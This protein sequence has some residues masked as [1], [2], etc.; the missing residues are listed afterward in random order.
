MTVLET[1]SPDEFEKIVWCRDEK[2]GLKAI[3]AIHDTTLGPAV[4]GTRMYPYATEEEALTDVMRLAKGMTYKSA[5][6]RLKLGGGKSVIIGDPEKDKTKARLKRFGQFVNDLKGKYVCAKDVGIHSKDL[7]IIAQETK[8]ILG[9]EG[10]KGSGGDPSPATAFGVLQAI[11]AL[12]KEVLGRT[13]L[14]GVRFAI[15]G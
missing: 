8:H 1:V 15:Q 6:S 11:R 10:V 9:V 2:T 3:I 4:G 13:S 7:R 14:D 12:A 5:I